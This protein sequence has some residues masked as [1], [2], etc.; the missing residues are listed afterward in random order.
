MVA[1]GFVLVLLMGIVTVAVDNRL[2]DLLL[3]ETTA[4]GTAVARSI[5][6][7]TSG[8]LLNYD[9]VTLSQVAQR[10]VQEGE[11]AYVIV[12]DKER[13]IAAHTARPELVGMHS[14]DLLGR[15]ATEN[16][17]PLVQNTTLGSGEKASRAIEVALPVRL[18]GSNVIWGTVR[19]GVSLEP[20]F[21]E[22]TRLRV[23]LLGIGLAGM[24]LAFAVASIL[25][26]RI[27]ASVN[28]LVRGT[29]AVSEGNWDHKIEIH[30]GDEI[31][32]LAEQFNR[33]T[34][35]VKSK[36]DEIEI[37]RRELEFLNGTLE[38]KVTKRTQ[39]FLASEEKY[40]ILVE[41][42]PDPI[43]IVQAGRL[44]FVNPA[45]RRALEHP[46]SGFV[47]EDLPVADLFLPEDRQPAC[48]R[49]ERIL[50]G[51]EV[52][53]GDVRA[54]TK[55]GKVRTFEMWG[56]K[57][58]HLGTPAVEVI[59]HDTTER[60]ELHSQL[61][62]HEKLRALGQLAGG[63]AHDFNNTLGII[64]GRAQLL[65]RQVSDENT[66]RSLK[67]IEKAAFDG[68]E[69]VRR[70]QDF[71][72]ARTGNEFTTVDVNALLQDVGE[73][74][75]TRWK[76]EAELR[77]VKIN[78]RLDL[79]EVDPVEGNASELR[80]ACTN[81]VFNAVDAMPHGG[82]IVLSSALLGD[83]VIL[84]IRD[85]GR[86]MSEEVKAR[87]FE[88]FFTTKGT[89]GMGLGLSVVYGIVERHGGSIQVESTPGRGTEFTIALSRSLRE[90]ESGKD[91]KEA[92]VATPA[93]ILAIDDEEDILELVQDILT[94]SGY[95]VRTASSGP[96]GIEKFHAE[97]SEVLLCDLGMREMTG[98]E[99]VS[100]LRSRDP[101][102]AVILLTGWG[103]ALPE[104]QVREYNIQRVLAKPFE[105][106][107]LLEA[108]EEVVSE[109][110]RS[111]RPPA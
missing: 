45:F 13:L 46:V 19:L 57:I 102:L 76:D 69:T 51:E 81:L 80:E 30:S 61:V 103:A 4:R 39:E 75:Q 54:R 60:N 83:R 38:D 100:A 3:R 89:E 94:D 82:E 31:A 92:W 25:S 24:G 58:T 44:R 91:T 93:K 96:L 41:N 11:L 67:T 1:V 78:V 71:A 21:T 63:V 16:Q 87:V 18:E 110:R 42:S 37:A 48:E 17:E 40:R 33:M 43:L 12:H 97:P 22:L 29:V 59:L 108:V 9:Y 62:Q 15:R 111:V 65:Q 79:S 47:R 32:T 86:G 53:V 66:L 88:P 84:R 95:E 73:I 68:G 109:K 27:V 10:A 101:D 56:M 34:A 70:I 7:T 52:E 98:W 5:A 26:R 72:R 90:T 49:I 55:S 50:Q 77:N 28:D 99:V 8:A 23:V 2:E 35:Q 107:K 106:S 105:M 20:M 85:S 14:T 74:T 6:A 36:Q 104:D 64:L